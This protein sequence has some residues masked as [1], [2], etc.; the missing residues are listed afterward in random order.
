MK[1]RSAIK[2]VEEGLLQTD[3]SDEKPDTVP[4]NPSMALEIGMIELLSFMAAYL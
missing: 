1:G 4:A 2:V 3:A